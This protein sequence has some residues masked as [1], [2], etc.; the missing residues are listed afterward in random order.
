MGTRPTEGDNVSFNDVVGLAER[1]AAHAWT[2]HIQPLLTLSW[3]QPLR[4]SA[5]RLY[6]ATAV[7]EVSKEGYQKGMC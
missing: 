7:Y 1:N 5:L 2:G 3:Y 4:E 6:T